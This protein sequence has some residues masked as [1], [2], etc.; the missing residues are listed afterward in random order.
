MW[1]TSC[2]SMKLHT[3]LCNIV[4]FTV[5]LPLVKNPATVLLLSATIFKKRFFEKLP[6]TN[7]NNFIFTTLKG[8]KS[9]W[10]MA[11]GIIINPGK[12]CLDFFYR[13]LWRFMCT[14]KI[15][16]LTYLLRMQKVRQDGTAKVNIYTLKSQKRLVGFKLDAWSKDGT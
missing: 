13:G 15:A 16:F 10:N 8:Y 7:S 9:A 11:R 5:A 3:N 6:T 12:L 4:F 14:Q 1:Q 2:I